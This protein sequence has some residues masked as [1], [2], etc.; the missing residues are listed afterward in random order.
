M[1]PQQQQSHANGPR[2]TLEF[3]PEEM[4]AHFERFQRDS[5]LLKDVREAF[6][7]NK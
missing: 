5:P 2:V 4:A 7:K 3:R 1:P 6:L